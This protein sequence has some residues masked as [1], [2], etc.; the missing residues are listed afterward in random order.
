MEKLQGGVQLTTINVQLIRF[1]DDI[2]MVMEKKED[3]QTNLGEM[4]KLMD[5]W[6]MK[7]HLGKTKAKMVS[8]T[9]EDC[10]LNIEGE[11]IETVK[12]LKNL[13][14]MISLDWICDE[15][16]EEHVGTTAKVVGA[17]RKEVLERRE[18]LRKTKLRA[19]NAVVVPTL[20][21]GCETWTMQ[22]RNESKL[23]A[24]KMMF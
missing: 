12:K 6:G 24:S 10:N 17:M 22:R 19:L 11:D 20:I 7:M 8:R 18:L 3:M 9:E 4:Q 14:A 1:T 13:G 23:Q 5:K 15:E 16:I 21:Y 2:E